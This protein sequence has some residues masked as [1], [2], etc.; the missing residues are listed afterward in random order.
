MNERAIGELIRS[1]SDAIEANPDAPITPDTK[2]T[3]GLDNPNP[4]ET[5][6]AKGILRG[7]QAKPMYEGTV[8]EHVK[9]RRRAKNKAARKSRKA[10][11]K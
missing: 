7:L 8:P 6:A 9:A 2:V 5:P 4:Y 3:R 11:R 10:N 1:E